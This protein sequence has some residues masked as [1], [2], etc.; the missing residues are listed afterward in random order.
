MNALDLEGE[1]PLFNT[2]EPT[3]WTA[4]FSYQKYTRC[5]G[6]I[7]PQQFRETRQFPATCEAE[8]RRQIRDYVRTLFFREYA[9]ID[10]KV[11]NITVEKLL[12]RSNTLN[13]VSVAPGGRK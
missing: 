13:I 1:L 2:A 3:L 5:R 6:V 9:A 8:V 7:V 12:T 11:E 10:G 4:R